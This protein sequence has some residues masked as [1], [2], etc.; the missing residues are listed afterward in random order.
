MHPTFWIK[1]TFKL[2]RPFLSQKFWQKL[3]YINEINEL[4]KYIHRDQISLPSIV[5]QY[6]VDKQKLEPIFGAPLVEV[7]ER[8][9]HV[10]AD[11]PIIVSKSVKYLMDHKGNSIF[12]KN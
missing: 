2:F 6:G 3:V 12:Q 4:Y 7:L 9:D 8:P 5:Y 10:D 1:T 11:V